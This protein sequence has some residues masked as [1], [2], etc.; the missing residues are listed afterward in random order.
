MDPAL[1]GAERRSEDGAVASMVDRR[2]LATIGGST[3]ALFRDAGRIALS[4]LALLASLD[5]AGLLAQGRPAAAPAPLRADAD[6][7]LRRSASAKQSIAA[8]EEALREAA[9]SQPQPKPD[10][11]SARP[12]ASPAP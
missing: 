10:P 11:V 7:L 12:P 1:V 8:R 2:P 3:M 6:A 4:S 5:A 9:V